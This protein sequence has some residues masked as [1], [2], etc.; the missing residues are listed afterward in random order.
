MADNRSSQLSHTKSTS[1]KIKDE[2]SM[3][4]VHTKKITSLNTQSYTVKIINQDT[5]HLYNPH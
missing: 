1:Q 3:Y 2:S 5:R 4:D